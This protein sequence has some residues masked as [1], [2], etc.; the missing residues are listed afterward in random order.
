MKWTGISLKESFAHWAEKLDV[1]P[2]LFQ[3]DHYTVPE[4]EVET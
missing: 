2:K 3:Q 4:T 1:G